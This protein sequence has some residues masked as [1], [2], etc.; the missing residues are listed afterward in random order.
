MTTAII[1]IECI[2]SAIIGFVIGIKSH[3]KEIGTLRVDQS[4]PY[5]GPY[6][7][8]ELSENP[9]KL[10]DK[11]RITLKVNVEDYVSHK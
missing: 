6:L 8:L 1:V 10:L 11:K 5:D 7:F 4:D 2:I 9:K 3:N